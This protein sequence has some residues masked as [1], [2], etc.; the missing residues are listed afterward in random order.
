MDRNAVYE[1][2]LGL[3]EGNDWDIFEEVAD[4][5]PADFPPQARA[6]H[7]VIG[8]TLQ[9]ILE[10]YDYIASPAFAREVDGKTRAFAEMKS[11]FESAPVKRRDHRAAFIEAL[12][13]LPRNDRAFDL[14]DRS[15]HRQLRS[16]K[17]A[18]AKLGG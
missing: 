2:I 9:A 1:V 18:I 6:H 5:H 14:L 12:A 11:R 8:R 3:V 15:L 7:R 10:N 16:V 17:E 4:Q 13:E